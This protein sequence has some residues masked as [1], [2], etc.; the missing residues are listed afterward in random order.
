MFSSFYGIILSF[1][2]V[3]ASGRF[4]LPAGFTERKGFGNAV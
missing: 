3:A 1:A 4:A 2:Q